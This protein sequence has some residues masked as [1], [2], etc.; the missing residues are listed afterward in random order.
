MEKTKKEIGE[1]S[2]RFPIKYKNAVTKIAYSLLK[3][4]EKDNLNKL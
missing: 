4:K 3:Q 1:L 2:L